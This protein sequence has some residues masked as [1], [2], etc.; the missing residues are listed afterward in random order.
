L[1]EPVEASAG[2]F[3]KLRELEPELRELEPEL[4]ELEPELRELEWKLRELGQLA[5]PVEAWHVG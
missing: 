3:D 4:R 1:A 2:P 5:E